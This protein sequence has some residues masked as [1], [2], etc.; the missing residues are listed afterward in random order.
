MSPDPPDPSEEDAVS[1]DDALTPGHEAVAADLRHTLRAVATA[2]P[3]VDRRAQL[4]EALDRRGPRRA[5]RGRRWLLAAVAGVVVGVLAAAV[6]A[7]RAGDETE[8]TGPPST[9]GQDPAESVLIRGPVMVGDAIGGN[10]VPF[11]RHQGERAA[12]WIFD[13]ASGRVEELPPPTD[14]W[15]LDPSSASSSDWVVISAAACPGRPVDD[16]TGFACATDV[17]DA[18]FAY[19]VRGERWSR[20]D[21]PRRPEAGIGQ[22]VSIAGDVATISHRRSYADSS[23]AFSTVDLGADTPTLT[24][25]GDV[26]ASHC[27]SFQRPAITFTRSNPVVAHIEATDDTEAR[28]VELPGET[29]PPCHSARDLLLEYQEGSASYSV[30]R[31]D[32]GPTEVASGNGLVVSL[33]AGPDWFAVTDDHATVVRDRDGKVIREIPNELAGVPVATD[34]GLV[35]YGSGSV[36]NVRV[37]PVR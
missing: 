7:Q 26:A 28:T 27:T 34:A 33:V 14:G 30:Y 32:D 35:F 3:S 31:L 17:P 12:V 24:P 15:L 19:D 1:P 10:L 36:I 25:R 2:T 29:V 37:E 23:L 18:I 21:V 16:D 8:R 5:D 20:V 13:A 22:V 4:L 11:V 9:D 6:V